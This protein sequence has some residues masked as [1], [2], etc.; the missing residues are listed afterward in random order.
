MAVS[1]TPHRGRHETDPRPLLRSRLAQR[2]LGQHRLHQGRVR[3]P[4]Q[5]PLP[6]ERRRDD[7]FGRSI[8]G[9][10]GSTGHQHVRVVPGPLTGQEWFLLSHPLS[11]I[12]DRPRPAGLPDTRQVPVLGFQLVSLYSHQ[13]VDQVRGLG[14]PGPDA[15]DDQQWTPGRNLDG[16]LAAVPSPA[17]RAEVHRFASV[18]RH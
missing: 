14:P 1:P 11:M 7:Q 3:A 2:V 6:T 13:R 15:L 9:D 10:L 5:W 4:W 16:S 12:L 18:K 17:R 8:E